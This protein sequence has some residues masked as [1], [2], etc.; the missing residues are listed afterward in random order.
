MSI[1]RPERLAM[2]SAFSASSNSFKPRFNDSIGWPCIEPLQSI[3]T[4]H[5]TRWL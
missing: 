3:T 2:S 4:T 5:G 1:T